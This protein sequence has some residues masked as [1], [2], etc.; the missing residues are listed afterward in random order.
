[1]RRIYLLD[2]YLAN[3]LL[4]KA[5]KNDEWMK[6]IEEFENENQKVKIEKWISPDGMSCYA[7]TIVE[8][9]NKKDIKELE[10]KL[11]DV[12]AA[13]EYEIAATLR[14]KI[15]EMKKEGL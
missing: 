5:K 2:L 14:D 3:E 13:E 9:K 10:S 1:M 7:K 6:T 4:S 11:K 12:V 15:K 8:P